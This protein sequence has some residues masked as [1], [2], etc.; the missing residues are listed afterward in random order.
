MNNGVISRFMSIV[1][2]HPEN[3]FVD[4][5]EKPEIVLIYCGESRM[6]LDG[7]ATLHIFDHFPFDQD[8]GQIHYVK[9]YPLSPKNVL[10]VQNLQEI[11]QNM[12][13]ERGPTWQGLMLSDSDGRRWKFINLEYSRLRNLRSENR[14]DVRM[15]QL[16]RED[17]SVIGEYLKYFPEDVE[18]FVK[19]EGEIKNIIWKLYH[20]YVD[21]HIK[22]IITVDDLRDYFR[23]HVYALHGL[24]LNILKARGHFIRLK[25][26][27]EYLF[28]QP[29]QRVLFLINR[30]N[31]KVGAD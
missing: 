5:I 20:Q 23:P 13:K 11:V 17:I 22:K 7:T 9:D 18:R 21:L 16:G 27:R 1:L 25:E 10:S 24:Y 26:V 30:I 15:I 12:A 3:R 31:A 29:W 4:V 28:K 14:Q 6:N 2:R 19:M 8:S